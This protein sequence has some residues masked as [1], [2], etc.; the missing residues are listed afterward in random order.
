MAYQAQS[1][2]KRPTERQERQQLLIL[3][4]LTFLHAKV[5]P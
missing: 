2:R 1:R 4:T 5:L 3:Q